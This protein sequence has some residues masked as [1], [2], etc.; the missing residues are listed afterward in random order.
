M[1]KAEAETLI[2]KPH[3]EHRCKECVYL[4]SVF[5]VHNGHTIWDLYVHATRAGS[6]G[7]LIARSGN[8]SNDYRTTEVEMIAYL[9][10]VRGEEYPLIQA[11]NRAKEKGMITP[12]WKL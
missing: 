9:C 8:D 11:Y 1:T 2:E 10:K 3:F 4:G 12:S 7:T 6:S 5:F